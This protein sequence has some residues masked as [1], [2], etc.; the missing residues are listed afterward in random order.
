MKER[1]GKVEVKTENWIMRLGD[2]EY[3]RERDGE[4]SRGGEREWKWW[5]PCVI[6]DDTKI[7]SIKSSHCFFLPSVSQD[8]LVHFSFP[9]RT[10]ILKSF[11]SFFLFFFFF[12]S[13][14]LSN[15]KISKFCFLIFYLQY[16]ISYY[17][18]KGGDRGNISGVRDDRDRD[19]R[20]SGGGGGGI[21]EKGPN[22]HKPRDV[23]P[24]GGGAGGATNEV[25]RPSNLSVFMDVDAPKVRNPFI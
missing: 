3:E 16:V 2:G 5:T 25:P 17:R 18:S 22:L 10:S 8:F 21:G 24:S 19:R 23:P 7:E 15:S 12:F 20:N 1:G 11:F 4:E 6:N 14:F 13:F 9:N